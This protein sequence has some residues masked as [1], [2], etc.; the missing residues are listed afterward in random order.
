MKPPTSQKWL[1]GVVLTFITATIGT[2]Q[3]TAAETPSSEPAVAPNH[4]AAE[5]IGS[6]TNVLSAE[7]GLAADSDAPARV[8]SG[9]K[10][11]PATIRPS[12][13][14][15]EVIKL[16]NSG[17]NEAVMLAFVTNSTRTFNLGADEIIYLNDVGVPGSVV[18]A[19]IQRDDVL[20]AMLAA[21]ASGASVLVDS[22]V[23]PAAAEETAAAVA[24]SEPARMEAAAPGT[25]YPVEAPLIPPDAPADD[26]FYDGLAPYG[27]WVDIAGYGPCWQ[28]TAGLINPGWQPYFDC[29]RW[30]YSDCGWYWLSDYSWGWAP[31]HYGCWFRHARLGWCW[32]PGSVWAPS[33]VAWRYNDNYC[34]WAPL[35]PGVTF[36]AGVGLTFHGH[37]FSDRDD[38]GLRPNHYHFVAWN[39]FH[40]RQLRPHGLPRQQVARVYDN[41]TIATRISGD[42]HTTINNGLPPSRVVAATRSPIHTVALRETAT[43]NVAGGRAEH[44]ETGGQTLA[45]YRPNPSQPPGI[46]PRQPAAGVSPLASTQPS[47]GGAWVPL[48]ASGLGV[49]QSPR[50][51]ALSAATRQ[52][53]I[54]RGAQA[55]AFQEAAPANSLVI[56]GSARPAASTAPAPSWGSAPSAPQAASA[57]QDSIRHD[58][59][60]VQRAPAQNPVN[61]TPVA[62]S[63]ERNWMGIVSSSPQPAWLSSG[64]AGATRQFNGVGSSPEPPNYQPAPRVASP[65]VPRYAP[66]PAPN[67]AP[68]R[69]Y[70]AP[71]PNYAPQRSYSAPTWSVPSASYE[72][73][74]APAAPSAPSAPAASSHSSS[75]AQSSGRSGR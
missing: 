25:A 54:L 33:W 7:P 4:A 32:Q 36:T 2:P 18:T 16:A 67:Y 43:P 64:E 52:P 51:G 75:T 74:P 1:L 59:A 40:D 73:R 28:P 50:G 29:G 12:S 5:A 37:R 17:L 34:G 10:P 65:E 57:L 14:V 8:I 70:S 42:G 63:Q 11:V 45:V 3:G 26:M 21:S 24:T 13:P 44:F 66:T 22:G 35:P 46:R 9:E 69:S 31:F 58:T 62:R 49:S 23:V 20:K 19:M 38:C 71:T 6:S 61:R 39:H 60:E 48:G 41:S 53:L 27:N 15:A 55:S 30:V 68:Q 56:I 72:A 47:T